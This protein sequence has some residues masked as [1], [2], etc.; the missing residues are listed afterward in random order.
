MSYRSGPGE[1]EQRP[2]ECPA[3]GPVDPGR[4]VAEAV[5]CGT[6]RFVDLTAVSGAVTPVYVVLA[7]ADTPAASLTHTDVHQLPELRNGLAYLGPDVDTVRV[8]TTPDR[9][10][11]VE[12]HVTHLD[13]L[14]SLPAFEFGSTAF[15]LSVR[16]G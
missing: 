9:R 2:S 8:R 4:S 14:T 12:E 6:A 7:A 16:L 1:D 5:E 3:D 10:Q 13:S 15:S 11:A